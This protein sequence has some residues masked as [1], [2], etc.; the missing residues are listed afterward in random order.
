MQSREWRYPRDQGLATAPCLIA[1]IRAEIARQSLTQILTNDLKLMSI[2]PSPVRCTRVANVDEGLL[3]SGPVSVS[4]S[5]EGADAVAG[6]LCNYFSESLELDS[7]A[8]SQVAAAN[9]EGNAPACA[10]SP[11]FKANCLMLHLQSL[12]YRC[13]I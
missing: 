5:G 11:P 13:K 2:I 10:L 12:L 8:E 7:L 3:L 1:G 4:F 6:Y 9:T